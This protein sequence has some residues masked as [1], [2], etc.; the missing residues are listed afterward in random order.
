ML[1]PQDAALCKIAKLLSE[2]EVFWAVGGATLL[3]LRGVADD[4]PRISLIISTE[5]MR[6]VDE[7][8]CSIG[9]AYPREL[10]PN[11]ASRFFCRYTIDGQEV[12]VVSGL[13][14]HY[15]GFFLT[16]PFRRDSIVS[17]QR[18][19]D[20]VYVPLMALEDWYVLFQM[21]PHCDGQVQAIERYFASVGLQ[22]PE[23]FDVMRQRSLPPA[24]IASILHWTSMSMRA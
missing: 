15:K 10:S 13:T 3:R 2:K 9:Q 11:F 8:F 14:L 4:S 24:V 1:H 19:A 16:Y 23:R 18:L 6:T 22:F 12:D 7:L 21:M 5:D 20:D 17:M